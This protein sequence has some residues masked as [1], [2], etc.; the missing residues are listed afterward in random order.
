M[1]EIKWKLNNLPKSEEKEKGIEFLKDEEIAKAKAF[2]ESFPQY[3]KTPLVKLDNLA[4]SLGVSGIYVKDESYR[5]GLN[6]FKVLGGSYSMGRYLAQRLNTDISELGYDKLTSKEI[7]E[8]LG[9]ITFFTATDGNHGRGVAWTANKLGQKSVVLMPKG[10]SEFRLNKIKGEGADASITDLNYD[11]AVRLAND[12][13]EADDHGVM[14]Q[15]TA[16][17]GYEE[18]PAWIMQGYGTMA[19]EAIEQ[20]KEYGVDRPTHVF[21]Q[22]GVGSLAGAVQGYVASIYDECPI[23]VVVEADEADCYYKSA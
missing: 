2:H 20:L 4:K 18:I 16:W 11:D 15:D 8:K 5:F 1:R 3:E 10:S 17:D 7:K 12:Y 22:A 13:A 21:V 19:K 14:V 23:T 6:A 9:E